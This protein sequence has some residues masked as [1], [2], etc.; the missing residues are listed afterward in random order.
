[1]AIDVIIQKANVP[2]NSGNLIFKELI[3]GATGGADP[4]VS[5]QENGQAF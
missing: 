5:L 3:P 4:L 1:M 2:G